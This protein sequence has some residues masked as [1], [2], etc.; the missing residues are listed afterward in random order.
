LTSL[1][2][3]LVYL[4]IA[5]VGIAHLTFA[6]SAQ[7]P[8]PETSRLAGYSSQ[9]SRTERDWEKK[10]QAGIVPENLRQNMQRLSARPHH[11]GSPYDKENADW[12]LS[13]FK[14]WAQR[15]QLAVE[16]LC[17][18]K[19]TSPAAVPVCF[20]ITTMPLTRC[21]GRTLPEPAVVRKRATY[22]TTKTRR[23][24]CQTGK[25]S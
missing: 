15:A 1:R 8:T 10:L 20:R 23:G 11:V 12:I 24:A 6:Q 19:R 4:A 7:T 25:E 13:K 9:S 3:F 21:R 16:I 5:I 2:S 18:N 17:R 14:E 22:K